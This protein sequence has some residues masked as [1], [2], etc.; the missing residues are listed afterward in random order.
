MNARRN[1]TRPPWP[2]GIMT[3]ALALGAAVACSARPWKVD[4]T[5][6]SGAGG[7]G[8][9][10]GGGG[11]AGGGGGTAEHLDGGVAGKMGW[12]G[13][14]GD[15]FGDGSGGHDFSH[16][17]NNGFPGDGG[18]GQCAALSRVTTAGVLF[19]VDRS[20]N[21]KNAADGDMPW[22]RAEN[23]ALNNALTQYAASMK[24]AYR[25]F[26]A[27]SAGCN[28]MDLWRTAAK[29]V[30]DQ[31]SSCMAGSCVQ[32][33]ADVPLNAALGAAEKDL[34]F[35]SNDP[36]FSSSFSTKPWVVVLLGSAPSCPSCSNLSPVINDLANNRAAT[37]VVPFGSTLD[38]TTCLSSIQSST[39]GPPLAPAT[40]AHDAKNLRDALAATMKEIQSETQCTFSGLI[41]PVS[42]LVVQIG[43]T[44]MELPDSQGATQNWL[45]DGY[46]D[47]RFV[48]SVCQKISDALA[49]GQKVTVTP[50]SDSCGGQHP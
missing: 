13:K 10:G 1:R 41:G 40:V 15:R 17:G 44:Q 16:G 49:Q 29:D 48:G 23:D 20:A 6:D 21:T 35:T 43:Q 9:G 19:L 47:F 39:R 5:G 42:R 27:S 12:G 50:I 46:Y 3:F 18:V 22:W 37:I 30:D 2:G 14:G 34:D 24:F 45:R 25:P 38:S 26:P 28:P 36:P 33:T 8:G 7:D 4:L 32:T 31:I 11:R